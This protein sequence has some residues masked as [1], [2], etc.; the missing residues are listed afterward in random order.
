MSDVKQSDEELILKYHQ[1]D[2]N[3]FE[4]LLEKYKNLVKKKA[5]ALY[6][7]GGERDDL[8]Q[9]GMIGLYKAVKNYDIHKDASFRT[10]ASMCINRQMCTAITAANR[11]KNVPLNESVSYDTLVMTEDGEE[12]SIDVLLSDNY[13]SNPEWRYFDEISAES[14]I[15]DILNKLSSYEQKVL[16]LHMEGHDY[17]DIARRLGR[18]PKS[19]DNALNR[20]RKKVLNIL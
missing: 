2:D 3:A 11:K 6:I 15:D 14:M 18:E 9:E 7:A 16:T 12:F 5:S 4:L 10:Y 19:V 13:E 17:L 1:G 8:I 20:I